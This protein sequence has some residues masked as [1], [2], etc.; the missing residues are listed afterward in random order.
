MPTPTTTT[1]LPTTSSS[2][3]SPI[4]SA[5]G[6]EWPLPTAFSPSH[7]RKYRR[8]SKVIGQ[9]LGITSSGLR[10]QQQYHHGGHG[11]VLPKHG[12]GTLSS[13]AGMG[14]SYAVG[15]SAFVSKQQQQRA[16]SVTTGG[17]G[18]SVTGGGSSVTGGGG[19]GGGYTGL[20]GLMGRVLGANA[21]SAHHPS[22]SEPLLSSD[23]D[24]INDIEEYD[25]NL[26]ATRIV[27]P[28]QPKCVS[29]ANGWIIALVECSPPPLNT[30]ISNSGSVG[31]GGGILQQQQHPQQQQPMSKL[32][33]TALIPPLRLVSR[34]NVRRGTT[35]TNI[36]ATTSESLVVL[37]PPIRPT[38]LLSTPTTP[39]TLAGGGVSR[40]DDAPDVN[41]GQIKHVFV[42]PTGCHT[43]LS[44]KN[45]EA[46][47]IHT[48][49]K[50]VMKLNGFGPSCSTTT[51]TATN[52]TTLDNSGNSATSNTNN[53]TTTATSSCYGG[54]KPGGTVN[55][56]ISGVVHGMP[57]N[58]V[59]VGLTP[60]SYV[61]AVGWDREY[62]TEGSTKRILLGT[63]MGELYE[64]I[65]SATST[66]TT[67]VSLSH[68]RSK[69]GEVNSVMIDDGNSGSGG[70]I[71]DPMDCPVLLHRLSNTT[72]TTTSSTH[73]S[74]QARRG[75]W[76]GSAV[77]GILFQRIMVGDSGSIVVIVS[78]GGLH[79]R[80]R[81][82]T[83]R[84]EL[85]MTSSL[86]LRSAF[87]R[88]SP[89]AHKNKGGGG[90]GGGGRSSRSFIELPGSIEY[91]DLCSCNDDSFAL[92]T[93]TG[94]YFGTIERGGVGGSTTTTATTTGGIVNAGILTY[95]S[96]GS[97]SGGGGSRNRGVI[98]TS[99]G[100]TPHH[101][102]TLGST[103]NVKF[104]NRV[105]KRVI[106]EERVDWLSLS[107]TSTLES[108]VQYG[109][110]VRGGVS[111][112]AA[113]LITDIRRPDQIWLRKERS[114][115]HISSSC[116]DR[117]VWKYTL[118]QCIAPTPRH[119]GGVAT[120]TTDE[121]ISSPGTLLNSEGKH[122]ESQFEHA[123]HLCSNA[124]RGK[125]HFFTYSACN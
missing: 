76:D 118:A 112:G 74:N 106:Q 13:N 46:Y 52:I 107:Q 9:N 111:V 67:S 84:S 55:E 88:P 92:R 40:V 89:P 125:M 45:G 73:G 56:A 47:Y 119:A 61:T 101:F 57:C 54:Y 53:A 102:I 18:S 43:L 86:T 71:G 30:A 120:T 124:V 98:P 100:L 24:I 35:T 123:M 62:G 97:S 37:P 8:E 60:G 19:G 70:N 25:M 117:D 1:S 77:C 75:G 44:A 11:G 58:T 16:S 64:Y 6:V 94:I 105:A 27:Y 26:S 108:D 23:A 5:R 82:Y 21:T 12:D 36:T 68:K 33:L 69:S 17:G 39:T 83:F 15:P 113:E 122:I 99:I 65:L 29:A 63:S 20:T 28:P 81:L 10:L 114:L 50:V 38:I 42:D 72:T 116:E 91:A 66:T 93:Q 51:N 96:L 34:W 90:G 59:Q 3:S 110:G 121:I 32:G 109:R 80:T 4:F 79:C 95:D 115:V 103:Q 104:I 41:Y 2:S 78:T 14:G 87:A 31:V 22:S 85:S 48:S 7:Y 49:M